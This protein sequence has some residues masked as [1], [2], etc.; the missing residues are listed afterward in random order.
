MAVPCLRNPANFACARVSAWL[1]EDALLPWFGGGPA[2]RADLRA[3]L[4]ACI[5]AG[6]PAGLI[7]ASNIDAHRSDAQML[8]CAIVN[9]G[10]GSLFP[11]RRK[12]LAQSAAAPSGRGRCASVLR[13][14]CFS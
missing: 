4:P 9:V 8:S 7:N 13:M 10:V 6:R 5:N 1:G 2:L 12:G 3:G 14:N 11:Q